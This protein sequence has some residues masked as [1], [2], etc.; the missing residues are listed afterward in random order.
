MLQTQNDLPERTRS[1]IIDLLNARLADALDL[2]YQAKQAHW[3]VKGKDFF[4]L[5]ELFDKVAHEVGEH[6]DHIAER[7][8]QLGGYVE[9]TVRS[10]AKLSALPEYPSGIVDGPDHVEALSTAIASVAASMR[11]A[12]AD[13]EA[14]GDLA[15]SDLFIEV[16]RTLDELLWMVEAHQ[17]GLQGTA[18]RVP[19]R[20][21]HKNERARTSHRH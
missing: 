8:V 12:I 5:H 19:A 20:E 13:T 4:Q 6:V 1:K 3:N 7:A 11:K 2:E 14:L 18:A 16:T 21:R 15:T 10:A 17:V 9:G